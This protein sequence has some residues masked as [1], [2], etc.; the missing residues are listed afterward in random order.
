[1]R[2]L[3]IYLDTSV[4]SHLDQQDA[5]EKM[6][7]THRLWD[8]IKAGLFDVVLSEASFFELAKCSQEKHSILSDFLMQIEYEYVDVTDD[9]LRTAELFVDMKILT[10]KSYVDCQHI[11]AAIHSECD[12]IVSWNFQHMVNV[13][14]I[15]GVKVIT[16]MEGR[17]DILIC[18]PNMLNEGGFENEYDSVP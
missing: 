9:V 5:P 11:S 12:V 7:D 3:K 4:I 16:A 10:R 13:R 1:M 14:T 18:S 2:K 17:K 6:R 15:R 8:N